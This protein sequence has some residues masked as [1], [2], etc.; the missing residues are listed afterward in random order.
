MS[1]K[2]FRI[3]KLKVSTNLPPQKGK[4]NS[5]DLYSAGVKNMLAIMYRKEIKVLP[6]DC[7][8]VYE[9]DNWLV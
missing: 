3:Q 4:G 7:F 2:N 8:N 6:K 5:T 9:R 1:I